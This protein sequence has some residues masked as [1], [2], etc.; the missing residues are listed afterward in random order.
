MVQYVLSLFQE[1][2]K[3][4][5]SKRSLVNLENNIWGACVLITSIIVIIYEKTMN[6][7]VSSY[8]F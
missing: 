8:D 6:L 1:K 2:K 7:R 5:H 3:S 4:L